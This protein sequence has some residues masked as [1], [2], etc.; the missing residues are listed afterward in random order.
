MNLQINC[1]NSLSSIE[2]IIQVNSHPILIRSNSKSIFLLITMPT[3]VNDPHLGDPASKQVKCDLARQERAEKRANLRN[4]EMGDDA[5][6]ERV[7]KRA[8]MNI[9]ATSAKI[10]K[11]CSSTTAAIQVAEQSP[12]EKNKEQRKTSDL[13]KRQKGKLSDEKNI[14]VGPRAATNVESLAPGHIMREFCKC[15]FFILIVMNQI[16]VSCGFTIF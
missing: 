12:H 1:N 5:R 15:V 3:V 8:V 2:F 14:P 11:T 6:Q 7:S 4:D 10:S 16:R 13:A 9:A